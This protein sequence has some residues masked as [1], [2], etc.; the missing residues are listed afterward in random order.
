[1]RDATAVV[2]V[3]IDVLQLD[4]QDDGLQ[5]I[6]PAVVADHVVMITLAAAV[7]AQDAQFVGALFV[8]G[9][10]QAAV[11]EAAQVL[12]G[13]KAERAEVAEAAGH[14]LVDVRTERL[15]AV[16]DDDQVVGVAQ[17]SSAHSCRPAG[18]TGAPGSPRGF[19]R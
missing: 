12:A 10:D 1:M 15:R 4:A 13:E 16:L 7:V 18:R 2:I 17:R 9:R 11:T 14:A 19:C 8:V 5:F 3:V 6:Q